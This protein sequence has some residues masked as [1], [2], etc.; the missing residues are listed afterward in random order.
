[1]QYVTI[2]LISNTNT[3]ASQIVEVTTLILPIVLRMDIYITPPEVISTMYF[4][5][6]T[7]QQYQH[8]SLPNCIV[9]LTSLRMRNTVFCFPNQILKLQWNYE[10]NSS[11]NLFFFESADFLYRN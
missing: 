10:I 5:N 7:H 2:I 11:K 1:M 6:H 8:Y 9:L 4:M 3:T